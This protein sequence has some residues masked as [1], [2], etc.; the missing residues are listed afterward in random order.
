MVD[1]DAQNCIIVIPGANAGLSSP[2]IHEAAEAIRAADLLLCQLEVPVET[3]LEAFRI[4]RAAGVQTILNPA[5]ARSLPD[6]LLKLTDLCV[7]NETEL[8]LLADQR[9]ETLEE[10]KSAARR[11]LSQGPATVIV[12]IGA[13]GAMGVQPTGT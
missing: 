12:T 8:E 2:H 4:A 7:P 5:P 1:D 10:T 6:E 9:V 13:R 3:V 11:L